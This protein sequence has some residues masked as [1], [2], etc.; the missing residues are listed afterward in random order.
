MARRADGRVQLLTRK[1]T[2][3][4]SR[5]PQIIE[6]MT[7]LPVRSCLIDGEAIVC[8]GDGLAV[9]DLLR[10]YQHDGAAVLCAFDLLELDGEDLRRTPIETTRRRRRS[11][12]RPRRTGPA[13]AVAGKLGEMPMPDTHPMT[14]DDDLL[15]RVRRRVEEAQGAITQQKG[16]VMRSRDKRADTSLA[17][18][19]LAVLEANLKR[20]QTHKDWLELGYQERR[21]SK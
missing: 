20:L 6:A 8:N 12:A 18:E 15:E 14:T 10:S 21:Q 5:F 11:G 9:F 3:F 1:G 16:R 17:E 13:G 19:T 2:N 4:A 7:G